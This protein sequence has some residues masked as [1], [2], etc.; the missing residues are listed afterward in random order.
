MLN[1]LP[2]DL[3]KTE[4][5]KFPRRLK[6]WLQDRPFYSLA[7]TKGGEKE[8]NTFYESQPGA[9]LSARPTDKQCRFALLTAREG[10]PYG[11]ECTVKKLK[12]IERIP[13]QKDMGSHLKN[14]K[15]KEGKAK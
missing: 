12:R 8:R 14:L 4:V 7:E 15:L 9:L 6:S 13:M 10:K 1:S 5:Q 3:K 2:E 11:N